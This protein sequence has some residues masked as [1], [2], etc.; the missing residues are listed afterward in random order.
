MGGE[1]GLGVNVHRGLCLV[2]AANE[3]WLGEIASAPRCWWGQWQAATG[4]SVC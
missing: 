2:Q 3:V 1:R 4:H